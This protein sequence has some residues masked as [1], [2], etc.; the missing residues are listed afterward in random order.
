MKRKWNVII[1]FVLILALS[2]AA[3]NS[4][5]KVKQ[6]GV[7]R[8]GV[9]DTYPPSVFRDEKNNI[10]GFDVDIAREVGKR[11]GLKVEFVPVDWNGVIL[12]LNANKYD[13]ICS[14]L[15]VSEER[16]K[17]I[18]FSPAYLN[19]GQV[20]VTSNK[21]KNIKSQKDLE[22]RTIGTQLGSTSEEAANA[23]P[24]KKSIRTYQKFTEVFM[25]LGIGRLD[26]G[27]VDEFV[28]RFYVAKDPSRFI[29]VE[30]LLTEPIAIGYRKNDLALA[31]VIN[32]TL[33]EMKKDGTMGKISQN[34]LGAD[35]IVK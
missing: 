15:S 8:V 34:W 11:L 12:A 30:S 31:E 32:K 6:S 4:W 27:I 5:D 35:I 18:L 26:A 9:D 2:G 20:I 25:D 21:T 3:D 7:L 19:V 1:F 29:F 23:L 16:A 24:F 33:D 17:A 28:A 22:G 14:A 13:M 10:V